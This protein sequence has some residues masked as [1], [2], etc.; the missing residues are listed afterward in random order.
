MVIVIVIIT[1]LISALHLA[2]R[3]LPSSLPSNLSRVQ[4][5]SAPPTGLLYLEQ[6]RRIYNLHADSKSMKWMFNV[7]VGQQWRACALCTVQW[8][9]R[10]KWDITINVC[11]VKTMIKRQLRPADAFHFDTVCFKKAIRL[12]VQLILVVLCLVRPVWQKWHCSNY[13]I[14]WNC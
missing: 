3:L 9:Y 2:T 8:W 13:Q 12:I 1:T 11:E 10:N 4:Q 5:A 7:C 14:V 6:I